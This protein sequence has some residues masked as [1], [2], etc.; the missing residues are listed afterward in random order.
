MEEDAISISGVFGACIAEEA[1][2]GTHNYGLIRR[3][4]ARFFRSIKRA[5]R[6]I[7]GSLSSVLSR[8]NINGEN[9]ENECPFERPKGTETRR[10]RSFAFGE[11]FNIFSIPTSIGEILFMFSLIFI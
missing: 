9:T 7:S 4:S 3:A 11:D 6:N 10:P 8:Q 5:R 1:E 2:K